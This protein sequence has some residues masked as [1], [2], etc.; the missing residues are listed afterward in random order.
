MNMSSSNRVN[1][2]NRELKANLT[3]TTIK[4]DFCRAT[5]IRVT[6]TRHLG[7]AGQGDRE[8]LAALGNRQSDHCDQRQ[9][10]KLRIAAEPCENFFHDRSS[11]LLCPLRLNSNTNHVPHD[12]DA[13]DERRRADA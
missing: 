1:A 7:G 8:A 5:A 3:L 2:G 13:D 9:Q 11:S 12:D 4:P 6:G 10:D